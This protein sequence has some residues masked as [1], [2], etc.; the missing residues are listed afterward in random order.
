M[1][2][3][4]MPYFN[5]PD[6]PAGQLIPFISSPPQMCLNVVE[7]LHVKET[8]TVIDLGCGDGRIVFAAVE[9][10]NCKGI[11][12]D[13]N[14]DLIQGC[15]EEAIKKGITDKVMFKVDDFTRE[16]FNFYDCN[17]ICFYFIP[18]VLKMLEEKIKNYVRS[19]PN[20][21]VVSI[22][23]PF[24]NWLPSKVHPDMKLFYYDSSSLDGKYGNN[25]DDALCPAF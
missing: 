17:C 16:D 10:I 4:W 5:E 22:C 25:L 9:N 19:N 23:F 12:V 14:E 18:K 2:H 20:K 11:G 8:E 1:E 7:M 21:R 13:I 15:N 6:P 3:E 24:R